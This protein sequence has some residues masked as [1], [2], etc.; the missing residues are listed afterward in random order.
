MLRDFASFLAALWR[1]WKVFLTGGSVVAVL[2]LW[3]LAGWKPIPHKVNWLI[4]GLTFTLAAFAAWRKEWIDSGRGFITVPPAELTKIFLA[5]TKV[6]GQTLQKPYVGKRLKVTGTV[7]DVE[8]NGFGATSF[9]HL[10]DPGVFVALFIPSRKMKPF[11][12]LPKG[13]TITVVGRI[14]SLYA[15]GIRMTNCE[16]ARREDVSTQSAALQSPPPDP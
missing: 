14:H 16:L 1:E 2:S 15:N 6:L 8:N 13:T 11:M 10:S 5:G 4:V 12:L 3:N 7:Y 9:V